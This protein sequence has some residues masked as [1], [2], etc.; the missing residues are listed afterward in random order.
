MVTTPSL[1]AVR[2]DWLTPPMP[3]VTLT[4]GRI[5][6][7]YLGFGLV[8][9]YVSDVVL[10]GYLSDPLLSQVQAV[11]GG[12]E[13]VATAGLIYALVR[14]SHTQL[15]TANDRIKTTRDELGL[16]HRVVRHNLRND[17]N[18]IQGHANLAKDD[19]AV[20]HPAAP[21]CET[22]VDTTG[23]MVTYTEQA[24][25]IRKV[26]EL[27]PER[28]TIDLSAVLNRIATFHPEVSDAV[29]VEVSVEEDLCVAANPML[30]AAIEEL[31]TN[32]VSHT[33]ADTP[34]I[35]L[36]AAPTGNGTAVVRVADNGPGIPA[37]E[38]A[39]LDRDS[40]D[41][42]RHSTGLGLWFADWTA[43]HSDGRLW[44]EDREDGGS[45]VCLAVPTA[46]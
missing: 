30:E 25:R 41:A 33:D 34:R 1:S 29:D 3:D 4:A 16:L 37:D 14:R 17:L 28:S 40:A 43:T 11:K 21:H 13:V 8:A 9:L 24:R 27:S 36:A 35:R 44:I 31:V 46:G 38:R 23:K 2:T 45:V 18:L 42:I 6:A 15:A 39:A 10:L 26:S 22:I 19:L 12:V 7:I 32:A 20:D 5:A